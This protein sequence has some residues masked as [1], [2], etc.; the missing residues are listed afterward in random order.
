MYGPLIC[1]ATKCTADLSVG[2]FFGGLAIAVLIVGGFIALMY[3]PEW[4]W[5]K[6]DKE[7]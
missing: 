7:N 5:E 2:E 4:N 6:K 1:Y 3:V